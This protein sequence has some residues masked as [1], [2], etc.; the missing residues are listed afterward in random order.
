LGSD[1][2]YLEGSTLM[3]QPRFIDP[4]S[5]GFQATQRTAESLVGKTNRTPVF[6]PKGAPIQVCV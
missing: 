1:H 6:I 2:D 3:N 4:V 5:L